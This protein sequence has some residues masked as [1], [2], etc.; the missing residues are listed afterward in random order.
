MPSL[1][2]GPL[3]H[4]RGSGGRRFP[5]FRMCSGSGSRLLNSGRARIGTTTRELSSHVANLS[6]IP[7]LVLPLVFPV[8]GFKIR[9]PKP[10]PELLRVLFSGSRGEKRLSLV[11]E[12][13]RD[14]LPASSQVAYA[15]HVPDYEVADRVEN[16]IGSRKD[17][18]IIRGVSAEPSTRSVSR[19]ADVALLPYLASAYRMR[20]SGMFIEVSAPGCP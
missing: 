10:T 8:Q 1:S 2:G 9:H 6:G 13:I 16:A 18:E 15:L 20:H 11:V 12:A 3:L 19:P 5:S 7:P 14:H 4:A 17:V